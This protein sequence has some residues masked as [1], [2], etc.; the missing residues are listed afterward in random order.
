MTQSKVTVNLQANGET[1]PTAMVVQIASSYASVIHMGMEGVRI[2]AKSIM[3]MLTLG[4]SSGV[5]LTV[6]ADGDDEAEAVEA[7]IKYLKGEQ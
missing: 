1:D 2:N 3:G 7:I 5:E 4:I 6:E